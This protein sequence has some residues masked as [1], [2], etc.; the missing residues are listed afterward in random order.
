MM[1]RNSLGSLIVLGAVSFVGVV[2]AFTAKDMLSAP[3][4]G[5]AV[6]NPNGTLAVYTESTYSFDT[7]SKT[8]GIYLLSIDK[9]HSSSKLLINDTSASD[10]AWLDNKTILYIYTKSGESSLH[11]HDIETSADHEIQ[12][13]PSSIGDLKLLPVDKDTIR[14]AFSTKVTPYGEI[15]PAKDSDTPD[16]LV[17]DKLWVRHWDEW[18]TPNKNSIFSSTLTRKDG[19]YILEDNV[20]NMLNSTEDIHD[21]ESP[22]PPFGGGEDFSMTSKL[23]AFVAKDPHLNPATNTASHIYIVSFNDSKYLERVNTGPGTSSS[24]T[25][26]PD[27]KYLAYLEMRVRGYEADRTS[28]YG[29]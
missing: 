25:W 19:K 23:L 20:R 4:S 7:D 3:R 28:S 6:P 2:L 21:L 5:P 8:G 14:I 9:K 18:I 15:L 22:V 13:F 26:S 16:V 29:C 24:P 11:T 1:M 12:S 17:Y 10:P 27:G